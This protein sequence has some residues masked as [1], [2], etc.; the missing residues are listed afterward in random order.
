MNRNYKRRAAL[1][2]PYQ[3]AI[4]RGGAR[5]SYTRAR[6]AR[7]AVSWTLN[8]AYPSPGSAT[9]GVLGSRAYGLSPVRHRPSSSVRELVSKLTVGGN[10]RGATAGQEEIPPEVKAGT[11]PAPPAAKR[12]CMVPK[13][14]QC[15]TSTIAAN[16]HDIAEGNARLDCISPFAL[17]TSMLPMPHQE[18]YGRICIKQQSRPKATRE[19]SPGWWQVRS[20]LECWLQRGAGYLSFMASSDAGRHELIYAYRNAPTI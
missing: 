4:R 15:N 6:K 14:A 2:A 8:L 12:K 19:L 10:G 7:G 3:M 16:T 9:R 20:G 5:G 18:S 11:V 13:A 17:M 1:S